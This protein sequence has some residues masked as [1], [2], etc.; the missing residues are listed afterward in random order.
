MSK[1]EVT[2]LANIYASKAKTLKLNDW[3]GYD[4][5]KILF[6]DVLISEL[7]PSGLKSSSALNLCIWGKKAKG[8]S[9][10]K[11]RKNLDML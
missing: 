2:Y 4:V 6:I 7:S 9:F 3:S 8:T 11:D 10:R 5:K 1:C